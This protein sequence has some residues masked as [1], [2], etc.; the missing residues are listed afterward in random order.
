MLA[1]PLRVTYSEL[2][3]SSR[4]DKFFPHVNSLSRPLGTTLRPF[5]CEALSSFKIR[6]GAADERFISDKAQTGKKFQV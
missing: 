5:A 1:T 4:K 2:G 3:Y 6:A